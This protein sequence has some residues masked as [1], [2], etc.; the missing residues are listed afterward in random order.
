MAWL[1]DKVIILG[2]VLSEVTDDA[3]IGCYIGDINICDNTLIVSTSAAVNLDEFNSRF[4]YKVH[5]YNLWNLF[6]MW[7]C[8]I[9]LKVSLFMII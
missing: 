3:L 4:V 7:V 8:L 6:S 1:Y 2:D 9:L 5:F